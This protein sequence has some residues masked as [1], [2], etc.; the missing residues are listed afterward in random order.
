[1]TRLGRWGWRRGVAVAVVGLTL[2]ACGRG[3]AAPQQARGGGGPGGPFGGRGRGPQGPAAVETV[4]AEL[5][6][7]AR[8]VTVSG[9]VEPIRSIGVNSQLAGE[10]MGVDVQEGDHVAVGTVLARLDRRELDAQ[11]SAAE[12][13]YQVAEAQFQRSEQ[14]RDRKVIT[15]PEYEKDRT[16]YAAA[17]AQL[18]QLKTRIGFATV[19]SPINGVVVQKSVEAGDAVGNQTRLFTLADISTLVVR[20]GVSELDVV[21]LH[22]GDPVDVTLDAFPGRHFQAHIRRIFPSADP[23]T[24]LVPV[25]VALEAGSERTVKPGFLARIGFQL[26]ARN[27]VLLVPGSAIV[28]IGGVQSVFLVQD[29]HA[30]KRT[31]QTGLTS[32][33]RVEVVTGLQPGDAV[34]VAGNNQLRD[35][36]EVNVTAGPGAAAPPA[37]TDATTQADAPTPGGQAR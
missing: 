17:K 12:A 15:L 11:L 37:T 35:G 3:D 8:S 25:E 23:G 36:A 24:R 29:G 26:D 14:L 16:A 18:D 5:G 34:V 4:A 31:V 30:L 9:V 7:I 33:G 21:E 2:A 22:V 19:T 27:N 20:V 10:L 6:S 13:A 1:M 32:E 28:G